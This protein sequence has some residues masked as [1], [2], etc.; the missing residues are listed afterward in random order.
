MRAHLHTDDQKRNPNRGYFRNKAHAGF[1]VGFRL[2]KITGLISATRRK[3][4]EF[5]MNL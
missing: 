1:P 4:T 2:C 5:N 3:K